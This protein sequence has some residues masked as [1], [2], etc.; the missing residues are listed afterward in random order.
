MSISTIVTTATTTTYFK[1]R[2]STVDVIKP[3]RIQ[4]PNQWINEDKQLEPT[5]DSERERDQAT[6]IIDI[7]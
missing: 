7:K 3:F 4:F 6:A 1:I 2:Y 5:P